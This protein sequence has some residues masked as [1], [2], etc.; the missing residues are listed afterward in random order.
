MNYVHPIDSIGMIESIFQPPPRTFRSTEEIAPEMV[1]GNDREP[2]YLPELCDMVQG[3]LGEPGYLDRV[4]TL[5]AGKPS[6]Q[7]LQEANLLLFALSKKA[8]LLQGIVET[9]HAA[10]AQH[11]E[12]PVLQRIGGIIPR[13]EIDASNPL[14]GRASA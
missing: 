3:H 8:C 14:I 11:Q 5:L 4:C 10:K 12:C 7:E 1:F 2:G 6:V 9:W 13:A